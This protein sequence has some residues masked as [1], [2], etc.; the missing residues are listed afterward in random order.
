MQAAWYRKVLRHRITL[1]RLYL[2]ETA[3]HLA[4]GWA[5]N[6]HGR[7]ATEHEIR[8]EMAF[9]ADHQKHSLREADDW[10]ANPNKFRLS[11][12]LAH[13]YSADYL[14]RDDELSDWF[15]DLSERLM[16]EEEQR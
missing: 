15:F 6:R 14:G 11:R 4:E 7:T 16:R 2:R 10:L 5:K 13:M 8:N 3:E 12:A 1:Q 9:L